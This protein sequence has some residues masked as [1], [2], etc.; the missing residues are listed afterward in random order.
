MEGITIALRGNDER[1]REAG[2]ECLVLFGSAA[3]GEARPDSDIDLL[4]VPAPSAVVGGLRLAGWRLMLTE[5]LG[6]EVDVVVAGLLR[7]D[8]RV[9]V[10]RE[11]VEVWRA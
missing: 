6:R 2:I 8:V 11:G 5:I 3:R 1:L 7:D 10:E 4:A 9:A